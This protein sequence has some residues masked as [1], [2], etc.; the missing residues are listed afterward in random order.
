M[1]PTINKQQ[2]LDWI[3]E[4]QQSGLSIAAF[5][6]ENSINVDNFY[7]HHGKCRKKSL[8]KKSAFVRAQ[9][10]EAPSAIKNQLDMTLYVGRS[11]LQIPVNISPQWLA[12]LMTFLA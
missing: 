4:Q 2:W 7:Y 11:R 8:S 6:R 1:K 3:E 12:A 5:C 9:L 10:I